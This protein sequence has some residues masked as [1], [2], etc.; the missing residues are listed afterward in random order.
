M[1]AQHI[2]SYGQGQHRTK[3]TIRRA[4]SEVSD[5]PMHLCSLI[6]VFTDH[7]FLLQ[8]PDYP[9]R[10]KLELLLYWVDVYKWICVL[11]GHTGLIVGFVKRWLIY[12]PGYPFLIRCFDN[13]ITLSI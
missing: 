1:Y 3:P 9:E 11:V 10:D 13:V 8:P 2:F 6:R 4:T 5:Q 7:M 12:F